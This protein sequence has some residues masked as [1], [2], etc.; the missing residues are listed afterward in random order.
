M[1]KL[2]NSFI[3]NIGLLI[4]GLFTVFSGLLIQLK[5]HIGNHGNISVNDYVF[6]ISYKSWSGFHK[7]SIV[8]LSVLM[9]FHIYLH[10]KWFKAVIKKRIVTNNKQV[11]T[12]LAL[13]VLVAITGFIPWFLGLLKDNEIPRKTFIEIHDKL[14]II[15]SAYLIL[16]IIKRLKWFFTTFE[17]LTNKHSKQYK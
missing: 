7:I 16:H 5:Y 4:S 8:I 13:F 3:I 14:A 9:I 1:G 15:L 12:L 6:G 17:K 2:F 11:L 10:W